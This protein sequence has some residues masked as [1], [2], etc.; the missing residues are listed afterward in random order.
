MK[1]EAVQR[2]YDQAR[3]QYAE[4]GVDTER[5]LSR[6][7]EIGISIHCWQGDD[8]TGFEN[9]GPLTGGI[10]AT[11]S[12]PGKARTPDE[13]RQDFEQAY[14]LIPGTHRFNLHAIY[15][16]TGGARVDRDEIGPEHFTGWIDWARELGVAL[17]FNPTF[18]SHPKSDD[19][20]TLAH[21][22]RA[23]REFWIE[24]GRR[25]RT[26]SAAMGRELGRPSVDNFWIPDGWKDQPADRLV[27]RKLLVESLDAIFAERLDPAHTLDAVESKLFGIAS[28]SYVV[29]SHEFYQAY[30]QSRDT[31][32]CMDAGHYHPTESIAEKVSALLPF[33]PKLLLHV[34]RPVRWDSDHVVLFDDETRAIM[35]EITRA[36]AW[37][38]VY[39]ALDF[40]DAS[41]NRIAAWVIGTRAALKS[42]LYSLLEP[43]ERIRRAEDERRLGDRLALQE[44]AKTLPFGAVWNEFCRREDVPAGTDWIAEVASYETSVL[45]KREKI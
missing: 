7:K 4:L 12:H 13:L 25:S 32:L 40:F 38:R 43:T 16:D 34:S 6:M 21:R 18:F 10:L 19:G 24:H 3:E 29:G 36:G 9:S 37:D 15:L 41:I 17:D 8:V 26:I 27:H 44:E 42:A 20:F 28:E 11:G 45:S 1:S 2:D 31:L 23:I 39:V 30:A 33:F 22:N 5:A 14:R 35:R